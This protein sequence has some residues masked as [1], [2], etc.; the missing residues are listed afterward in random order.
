MELIELLRKMLGNKINSFIELRKGLN[1]AEEI[2]SVNVD[3][4]VTKHN[5]FIVIN[6]IVGK[7]NKKATEHKKSGRMDLAILCLRKANQILFQTNLINKKQMERLVEFLKQD[8]QFEEARN[9]EN[10]IE[11]YF[12]SS[13]DEIVDIFADWMTEPQAKLYRNDL[14]ETFDT[15]FVCPICAKYTARIFSLNGKNKKF[16]KMPDELRYRNPKEHEFCNAMIFFHTTGNPA[17]QF[18]GNLYKYCNRPFVDNRTEE[19]K[20]HFAMEVFN[21]KQE[22]RDRFVYDWLRENMPDVA[23]KSFAG[24]RKMKNSKSENYIKLMKQAQSQGL[25]Q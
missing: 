14:V 10:N 22:R 11:Q 5:S 3:W 24:F 20:K 1:T 12:P 16:P 4:Y 17:F 25:P 9:E 7:L 18:K 15:P 23:P 21:K 13:K 6:K 2:Q 19:Q 8:K